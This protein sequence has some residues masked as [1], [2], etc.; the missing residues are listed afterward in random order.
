MKKLSV[1][2]AVTVPDTWQPVLVVV[3]LPEELTTRVTTEPSSNVPAH[4]PAMEVI[5][6]GVANVYKDEGRAAPPNPVCAPPMVTVP[7]MLDPGTS[8][9]DTTVVVEFPVLKNSVNVPEKPEVVEAPLPAA[10]PFTVK[11]F[12]ASVPNI[13]QNV[14]SERINACIAVPLPSVQE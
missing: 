12:E 10:M 3:M 4:V 5:E 1:V 13:P 6:A 8:V 14:S 11:E 7:L 9:A 2:L